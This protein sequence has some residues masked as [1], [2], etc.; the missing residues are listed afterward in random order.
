[1]ISRARAWAHVSQRRAGPWLENPL[2][3]RYP[4]PELSLA[5]NTGAGWHPPV[6]VGDLETAAIERA[7]ERVM[8]LANR[9]GT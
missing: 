3:P 1:M 9:A 2:R 7:N 8:E 4:I 5:T 6:G